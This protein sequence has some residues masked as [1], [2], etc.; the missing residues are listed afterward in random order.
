ML[1]P[2]ANKAKNAQEKRQAAL[3]KKL[4]EIAKGGDINAVD[5]N[6][7]T[8]LMYAAAQDNRL[9]VC[10]LVAKGADVMCRDAKKKT[11]LDYT[12]DP[13]IGELL[14]VCT[15][16]KKKVTIEEEKEMNHVCSYGNRTLR[17]VIFEHQHMYSPLYE[18]SV[19]QKMGVDMSG[20][21]KD[22]L[23]VQGDISPEIYAFLVRT[24]YDVNAKD[25][26][27]ETV[28]N[29]KTP[30]NLAQL[31]LALDMKLNPENAEQVI[32][33]ALHRDD[34]EG[35]VEALKKKPELLENAEQIIAAAKSGKM[36]RALIEAGL[37]VKELR[38]QNESEIS[39][40]QAAIR[41]GGRASVVKELLAAGCPVKPEKR[42]LLLEI[43]ENCPSA[44]DTARLL[45]DAGMEVP[46]DGLS[47]AVTYGS[48]PLVKLALE[49]GADAKQLNKS[50]R[51]LLQLLYD[52]YKS[53]LNKDAGAIAKLLINAGADVN[54]TSKDTFYIGKGGKNHT[55]DATPL[56]VAL[57]F[58][59]VSHENCMFYVPRFKVE[60]KLKVK[61]ICELIDLMDKV[62]ED[63]LMFVKS[64]ELTP[65]QIGD[66]ALKML[67]KGA[68]V[69]VGE[70]ISLLESI[71]T[72]DARVTKRLLAA[73]LGKN[74][75]E[76]TA[77]LQ[78]ART[79]EVVDVLLAAG[80]D[81]N[82]LGAVMEKG[83]PGCIHPVVKRLLEAG[84][85]I[86][87]VGEDGKKVGALHALGLRYG[88]EYAPVYGVA[89]RGQDF[90]SVAQE[91]I[92]AGAKID[93]FA[94][95]SKVCENAPLLK[96]VLKIVPDI[97]A[98]NAA[99]NTIM[100]HGLIQDKLPVESL[101]VLLQAGAS[102]DIRNKEGKTVL[103]I[104]QEKK[105]EICKDPKKMKDYEYQEKLKNLEKL[106]PLLKSSGAKE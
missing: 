35:V 83:M 27:G 64:N 89:L 50:G 63:I 19:A 44:E 65:Q 55:C 36:V 67:D 69:K 5:K 77:A 7:Q 48:L 47:N 62:P 98:Q 45:A 18:V 100:M 58:H 79:A 88:C 49:K 54:H 24:G 13:N 73:G 102:T 84:A 82:V 103:K 14:V 8:A 3:Q 94:E 1:C 66:I 41:G 15:R 59:L 87:W 12:T 78:N 91:L 71:G 2:A 33:E 60:R 104:A 28:L 34:A 29:I 16:Q 11:A 23:V 56:H 43:A 17:E 52:G 96:T 106:I 57:R 37:N 105:D 9:A 40:F 20:T 95:G 93:L 46:A 85:P 97:N 32:L 21:H 31:M 22:K 4:L 68:S 80:A 86:E 90:I 76:L 61:S 39:L 72:H 30:P 51:N 25:E 99:G 53:I 101:K 6:G 75:D 10:W 70:D 74:K 26:N 42:S 92:K 81:K 38:Q